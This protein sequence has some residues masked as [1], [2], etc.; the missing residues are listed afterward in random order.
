FYSTY[1]PMNYNGVD[2]AGIE[3]TA[4]GYAGFDMSAISNVNQELPNSTA[5]NNVLAMFWD[6]FTVVYDAASNKG[7]TAVGDG[8]SLA[9]LEFDD[10]QLNADPTKT[11]DMEIG[12]FL[13]P[14]DAPGAHEIIFAYD[15]ITPGLFAAASGTIGVEN[16]DGTVGTLFSYN[17]T[18]LE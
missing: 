12:Y 5:P 4:D 7:L 11:L 10:I 6:D 8:A 13:Q 17:D 9:T 2:Y 16:V 15:N 3:I 14:D 18:A 1:P